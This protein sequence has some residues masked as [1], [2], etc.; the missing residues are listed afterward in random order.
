M[1]IILQKKQN[2]KLK[3]VMYGRNGDKL[4]QMN[5]CMHHTKIDKRIS[6]R[7]TTEITIVFLG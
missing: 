3:I 5:K 7:T 4:S 1:S 6:R 2:K